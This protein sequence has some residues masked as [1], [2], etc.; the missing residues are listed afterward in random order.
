MAPKGFH[1]LS[2]IYRD[3]FTPKPLPD[4]CPILKMPER[5]RKVGYPNQHLVYNKHSMKWEEK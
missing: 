4:A 3:N 1:D 2:S 5:P